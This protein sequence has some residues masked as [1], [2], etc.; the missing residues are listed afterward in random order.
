MKKRFQLDRIMDNLAIDMWGE[1]IEKIP[2]LPGINFYNCEFYKGIVI[3]DRSFKMDKELRAKIRPMTIIDIYRLRK[4]KYVIERTN[5]DEVIPEKLM[6]KYQN[7]KYDD[8]ICIYA[9]TEDTMGILRYYH[10]DILKYIYENKLDS[11]SKKYSS[12]SGYI[13][14]EI[15]ENIK[16][17]A[18]NAPE[19]IKK[20]D[21]NKAKE[22]IKKEFN[23]RITLIEGSKDK[24]TQEE[25]ELLTDLITFI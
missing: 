16:Y 5:R 22:Q 18:M 14:N 20:K 13:N 24:I 3:E 21:K 11:K 7:R 2:Y 10:R 12:L 15:K 1:I 17:I 8:R 4:D 9:F 25:I 23:R 6:S 19:F